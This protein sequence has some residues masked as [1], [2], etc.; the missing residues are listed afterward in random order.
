MKKVLVVDDSEMILVLL[1]KM[2]ERIG[3]F[4]VDNCSSGQQALDCYNTKNQIDLV[5]TDQSM[6]GMTGTEL[7]KM[8]LRIKPETP[9]V[10]CTSAQDNETINEARGVGIVGFLEKPFSLNELASL[11][12]RLGV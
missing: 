8:I 5:I 1:N 4:V 12:K 10:L 6:P 11:I 7:A 3:G 9:I 2:L